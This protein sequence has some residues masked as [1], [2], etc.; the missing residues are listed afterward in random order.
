MIKTLTYD[1]KNYRIAWTPEY[2]KG[3]IIFQ[4]KIIVYVM[5]FKSHSFKNAKR[6]A[7][8][9]LRAEGLPYSGNGSVNIGLDSN[10]K[11]D[12]L[13]YIEPMGMWEKALTMASGSH[14]PVHESC[15]DQS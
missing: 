1:R 15:G 9:A 10:I 11:G 12:Y 14:I 4:R 5:M 2:C 8:S 3:G 13:V 7:F 6:R